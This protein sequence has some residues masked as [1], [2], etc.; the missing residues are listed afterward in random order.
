MGRYKE[1]TD[2]GIAFGATHVIPERGEEVM[3]KGHEPTKGNE[4]T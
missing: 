2:L 4:Y 1:C 3:S